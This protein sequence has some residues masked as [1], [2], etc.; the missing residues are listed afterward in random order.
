[1][2]RELEA[3]TV[4]AIRP[5]DVRV[6][7]PP[8]SL[9]TVGDRADS[10]GELTA[11]T[12]PLAR[13]GAAASEFESAVVRDRVLPDV[14]HSMPSLSAGP[15]SAR[16]RVIESRTTIEARQSPT[17]TFIAL[18]EPRPELVASVAAATA[19]RPVRAVVRNADRL[20]GRLP[21]AQEAT[22]P[23][24]HVSIGRVEVRAS[25]AAPTSRPQTQ[26]T[27]SGMTLNEYLRQR[28]E[29]TR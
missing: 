15:V 4:E 24:I 22:V 5:P 20:A 28:S 9:A 16:P 13:D 10:V 6:S 26:A 19:V 12:S 27:A 25:T 21:D 11:S 18:S 3:P 14:L 2:D 7:P 23:E 17:R 8:A 29:A 1:V